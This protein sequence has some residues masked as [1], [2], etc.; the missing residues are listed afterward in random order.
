[1]PTS[2]EPN[3]WNHHQ[4][5]LGSKVAGS[6]RTLSFQNLEV[7]MTWFLNQIPITASHLVGPRGKAGLEATFGVSGLCFL[8]L[9]NG[10][11]KI[12][13]TPQST[14]ISCP[15]RFNLSPF[16]LSPHLNP[17]PKLPAINPLNAQGCAI[18]CSN[19][20]RFVAFNL[21][22]HALYTQS[23]TPACKNS[24]YLRRDQIRCRRVPHPE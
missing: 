7:G 8:A 5:G 16:S 2:P 19:L 17:H 11:I 10:C 24:L 1:M 9:T 6:W 12:P 22:A 21:H 3:W 23:H 18:L 15:V 13:R 4:K 14:T 20:R